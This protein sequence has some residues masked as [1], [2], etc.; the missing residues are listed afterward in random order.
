MAIESA[1]RLAASIG[2][3]FVDGLLLKACPGRADMG[4]FD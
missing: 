2:L 4:E 3:H 1:P